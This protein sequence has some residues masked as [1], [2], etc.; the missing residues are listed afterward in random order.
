MQDITRIQIGWWCFF[1]QFACTILGTECRLANFMTR[2]T[3]NETAMQPAIC[4]DLDAQI[5]TSEIAFVWIIC[6]LKAVITYV[7]ND[8]RMINRMNGEWKSYMDNQSAFG[9]FIF[10]AARAPVL[11]FACLSARPFLPHWISMIETL[12]L[13]SIGFESEILFRLCKSKKK[14]ALNL[15]CNIYVHQNFPLTWII[16]FVLALWAANNDVFAAPRK[17]LNV[18]AMIGQRDGATIEFSFIVWHIS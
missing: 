2:W 5:L 18:W 4:H 1:A 12:W 7:F 10:I 8:E 9:T 14:L 13:Q 6:H 16:V 17:L 11:P 15:I 3:L